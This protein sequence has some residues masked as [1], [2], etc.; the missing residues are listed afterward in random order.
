MQNK[1]TTVV[2][3]FIVAS[4]LVAAAYVNVLKES[5]FLA[6]VIAFIGVALSFLFLLLERRNAQLVKLG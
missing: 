6:V 2:N 5:K 3:Y 1:R 4:G